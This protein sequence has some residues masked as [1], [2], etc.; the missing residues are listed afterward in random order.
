MEGVGHLRRRVIAFLALGEVVV[1]E[2]G[3][4]ERIPEVDR[5]MEGEG[6]AEAAGCSG[7]LAWHRRWW[8]GRGGSRVANLNLRRL[9]FARGDG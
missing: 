9:N 2:A 5:A 4:E 7:K 3:V 8:R 1:A 6:E